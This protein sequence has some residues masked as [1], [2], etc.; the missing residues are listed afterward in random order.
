MIEPPD[1]TEPD[2]L[3][4]T[5]S[6]PVIILYGVGTTVGAGIYVLVGEVAAVA[7]AAA[8]ISFLV[9]AV[10]AGLSAFSFAEL[11]GRFPASAGEALY[12]KIAFRRTGISTAI[13]L[14][15]VVAGTISVATVI[16]GSVGYLNEFTAAPAI[17]T[18]IALTILL[19]GI[20]AWGIAEAAAAAAAMTLVELGGLGLVIW[21]GGPAL[22]DLPAA[23]PTM[24]PTWELRPAVAVL[25]GSV[26]AFFAFIGFEDMV[27]VAEEV[28]NPRRSMPIAIIV[29]LG[30]TTVLYVIVTLIAVVVLPLEELA[31]TDAPLARVLEHGFTGA[32]QIVSAISLVA[33]ANGALIQMIMGSR[34]LYGLG[35]SSA[36]PRFPCRRQWTNTDP[37]VCYGS[38]CCGR[39]Y[40]GSNPAPGIPRESG[41]V[42]NPCR[43]RRRGPCP[44][45]HQAAGT[46]TGGS[47]LYSASGRPASRFPRQRRD[48]RV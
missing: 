33:I 13:G 14:L 40:P 43:L 6:L 42:G 25:A 27:N 37:F 47:L 24:I 36:A 32:P 1:A 7:G 41:V 23:L 30:V 26:V 10:L 35:R 9:A 12:T 17:P 16:R 31:G 5:L 46:R 8:P 4:R 38:D 29:T 44:C 20:A 28:K 2:S 21:V 19:G 22:A 18:V 3:R 48:R 39:G 45:D 15:V 34:V 11:C